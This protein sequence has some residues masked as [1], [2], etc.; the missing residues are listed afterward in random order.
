MIVALSS[1]DSRAI[2]EELARQ[3]DRDDF[4]A[5]RGEVARDAALAACEVE[6][7]LARH[8]SDQ[9]EQRP[10]D[11]V[12]IRRGDPGVVPPR[13]LVEARHPLMLSQ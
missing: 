8:R 11:E 5:A 4:V 13:V 12:V 6:D 9:V 10:R 1:W 2:R 7:A 3:I